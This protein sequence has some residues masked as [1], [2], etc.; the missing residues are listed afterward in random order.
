MRCY[1]PSCRILT[2]I[3]FQTICCQTFFSDTFHHRK[4]NPAFLDAPRFCERNRSSELRFRASSPIRDHN[5]RLGTGLEKMSD[6][7]S[8]SMPNLHSSQK[9]QCAFSV[10]HAKGGCKRHKLSRTFEPDNGISG[11]REIQSFLPMPVRLKGGGRRENRTI[12]IPS[13]TCKTIKDGMEE[14]CKGDLAYVKAG[15]YR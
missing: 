13:D 7:K 15:I 4:K 9:T 11:I 5:A 1:V 12:Y 3:I 8:H 6:Q 10:S 14:V 2:G